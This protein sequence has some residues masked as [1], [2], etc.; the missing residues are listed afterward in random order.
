MNRR[1]LLAGAGASAGTAVIAGCLGG[2]DPTDDSDADAD[3]TPDGDDNTAPKLPIAV[4]T[5]DAPGSEAGTMMVPQ[6]DRVLLVNFTRTQCPT[7]E[8]F[9]ET[10]GEARATLESERD[11]ADLADDDAVAFLSVTNGTRGPQP[12]PDELAA[13]WDEHDGHWPVGIDRDGALNDYYDVAGF[14][15][16]VAVDGEG[17][18]HWRRD[19]PT[20]AR[21]VVSGIEDAL[22]AGSESDAGAEPESESEPDADADA[23]PASDGE[24]NETDQSTTDAE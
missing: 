15:T 8:G 20:S 24:A 18:V 10:L 6:T 13:W 9:L 11:A 4:E 19:E 23:G 7:S 12:S 14:P 21:N 2:P 22:E 17:M 5:V 3:D 1:E 16:T